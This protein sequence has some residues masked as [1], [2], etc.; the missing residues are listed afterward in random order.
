MNVAEYVLVALLLSVVLC[1]L[2]DH[3]AQYIKHNKMQHDYIKDKEKRIASFEKYIESH[4]NYIK[5]EDKN[6][7]SHLKINDS[8]EQINQSLEEL[9]KKEDWWTKLNKYNCETVQ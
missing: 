8:L 9:L 4:D 7:H 5:S 2:C 6:L 3:I 1:G